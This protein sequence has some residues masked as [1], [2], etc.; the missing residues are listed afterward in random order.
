LSGRPRNCY[1]GR[2][3]I[4]RFADDS[5]PIGN[6]S[7]SG[8]WPELLPRSVTDRATLGGFAFS[9]VTANLA[10]VVNL[11]GLRQQV[12][13]GPL[14]ESRVSLFHV[15]GVAEGEGNPPVSLFLR[16]PD[17]L[18]IENPTSLLFPLERSLQV[19]FGVFDHYLSQKLKITGGMDPF[20]LSYRPE[21]SRYLGKLL[22]FRFLG[23]GQQAEVSLGLPH[24]SLVKVAV[25]L[26]PHPMDSYD[27]TNPLAP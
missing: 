22:L 11:N 2:I 14:V 17:E 9:D 16:F 15:P 7:V 5:V 23:V 27:S 13:K 21:E 1:P 12:L 4:R 18:G 25:G 24:K 26:F 19:G 20:S 6:K 8:D 10:Y 3:S